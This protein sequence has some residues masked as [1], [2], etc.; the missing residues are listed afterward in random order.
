MA[1]DIFEDSIGFNI[2]GIN[3]TFG[4]IK[5]L[6]DLGDNWNFD[7]T[8]TNCGRTLNF[9]KNNVNKLILCPCGQKICIQIKSELM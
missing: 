9:N 4:E 3:D 2:T 5:K 6:S 8:C 7:A 1:N